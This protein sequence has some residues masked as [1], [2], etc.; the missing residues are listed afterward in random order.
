VSELDLIHELDLDFSGFGGKEGRRWRE[1]E[2]EDEVEV[3]PTN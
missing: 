1:V 3:S 2:V